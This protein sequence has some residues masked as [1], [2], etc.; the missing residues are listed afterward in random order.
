MKIKTIGRGCTGHEGGDGGG[1]LGADLQEGHKCVYWER[2]GEG[3]RGR[4][5]VFGGSGQNPGTLTVELPPPDPVPPWP[6]SD[7]VQS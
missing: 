6:V 2:C 1:K 4:W 5:G 3:R 7:P